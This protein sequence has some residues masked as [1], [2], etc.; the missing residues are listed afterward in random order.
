MIE[1]DDGL[2]LLI[3]F[4]GHFIVGLNADPNKSFGIIL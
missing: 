4:N 3:N 2:A 1:I